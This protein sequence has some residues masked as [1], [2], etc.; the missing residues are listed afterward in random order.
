MGFAVFEFRGSGTGRIGGR[1]AVI[2]LFDQERHKSSA[3]YETSSREDL[4]LLSNS[5]P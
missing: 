2:T 1:T 4:I 3:N 5:L